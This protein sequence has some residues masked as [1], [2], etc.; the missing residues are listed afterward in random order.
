M[1]ESNSAPSSGRDQPVFRSKVQELFGSRVVKT[2]LCK[3]GTQQSQETV[4]MVFP[5]HYPVKEEGKKEKEV[6]PNFED[7]TSFG[8]VVESSICSE[9]HTHAW[10]DNCGK[11]KSAVSDCPLTVLQFNMVTIHTVAMVAGYVTLA[12]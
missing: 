11:F 7:F 12:T 6:S 8:T 1:L 4:E 10:C 9:Q 2:T 3:C 5:L